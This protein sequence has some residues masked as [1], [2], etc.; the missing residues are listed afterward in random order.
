[1]PHLLFCRIFLVVNCRPTKQKN[2]C[3]SFCRKKHPFAKVETTVWKGFLRSYIFASVSAEKPKSLLRWYFAKTAVCLNNEIPVFHF[4]EKSTLLPK[5][6]TTVWK[7]FLRSCIFASVSAETNQKVFYVIL[8][9]NCRLP[10]QR[11]ACFSFCQK[12]V[13]F[14][15][16]WKQQREKVS[17]IA[18]FSQVLSLKNQKV[19]YGGTFFRP[20]RQ[21]E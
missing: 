16:S 18:V 2:F 20:Q 6:K 7:G 13:I 4:V 17:L 5:L 21:T 19:Y 15:Q 1:M 10:K 9:K 14:C 3:F 8:C 12:R 11:N